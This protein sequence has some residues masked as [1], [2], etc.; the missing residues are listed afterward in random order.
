MI[1]ANT[2]ITYRDLVNSGPLV[3]ILFQKNFPDGMTLQEMLDSHIGWI[4]EAAKVVIR[5]E[6]Q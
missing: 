5:G 3:Q 2:I 1:N 6:R 4:I